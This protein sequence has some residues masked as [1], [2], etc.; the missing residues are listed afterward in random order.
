MKIFFSITI[1]VLIEVMLL[2][3]SSFTADGVAYAILGEIPTFNQVLS[4]NYIGVVPLILFVFI[5]FY[6]AVLIGSIALFI[7]VYK[8]K[9]EWRYTVISVIALVQ[10]LV[11]LLAIH[12]R[13]GD[14]TLMQS[15]FTHII[16]GICSLPI[17]L[18]IVWQVRHLTK[19]IKSD[20]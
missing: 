2:L 1:L 6:L 13:F 4:V 15:Y 19:V 12:E 9:I 10:V 7:F 20:S 5:D 8:K 16:F 11:W 18:L 14:G 3:V 17:A